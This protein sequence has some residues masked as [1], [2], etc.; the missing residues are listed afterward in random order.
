VS[1]GPGAYL[2]QELHLSEATVKRHLASIYSKIEVHSRNAA[3]RMAITEHWIG[4]HEIVSADVPDG[5]GG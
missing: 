5:V 3:V 1:K 2:L 4:T